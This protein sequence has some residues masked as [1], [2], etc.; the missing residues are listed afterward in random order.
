MLTATGHVTIAAAGVDNTQLQNNRIGFAD[1]NAIEEF[2]LINE[3]TTT[4][5]YRGLIS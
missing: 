5:G 2:E 4:T 3:L 1:G